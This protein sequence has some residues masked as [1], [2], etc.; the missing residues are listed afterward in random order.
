LLHN[1]KALLRCEIFD[2]I[3]LEKDR[4]TKLHEQARSLFG[5]V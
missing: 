5:G 3:R 1:I 4:S 2:L